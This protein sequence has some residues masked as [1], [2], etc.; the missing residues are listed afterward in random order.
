MKYFT[1]YCSYIF[2]LLIYLVFT[3]RSLA[4]SGVG[5]T[6]T[7]QGQGARIDNPLQVDSITGLFVAL[8]EILTIFAI[9]IVVFF[10]IYAGFLYVTARGNVDQVTQAH[11]ALLYAVIGGVIILGGRVLIEVISGTV[12]SVKNS[13]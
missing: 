1:T 6:S 5:L 8:L 12:D 9:P 11:R 4:Q 3:P 7:G 13:Q 10:I 2:A